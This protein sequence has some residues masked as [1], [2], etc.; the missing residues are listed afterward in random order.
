MSRF[1]GSNVN[2]KKMNSDPGVTLNEFGVIVI[3]D[4]ELL[5]L[6]SGGGG[7][8][9]PGGGAS[10]PGGGVNVG[11]GSNVGCGGGNVVCPGGGANGG[12]VPQPKLPQK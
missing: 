4:P 8:P 10:S 5:D 2:H 7:A 12:C 9:A 6:I 1:E 3:D 11:C